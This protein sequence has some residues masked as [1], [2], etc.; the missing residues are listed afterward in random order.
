MRITN[1]FRGIKNRVLWEKNN[2]KKHWFGIS[3]LMLLIGVSYTNNFYLGK[4][5]YENLME[6]INHQKVGYAY[7]MS[8]NKESSHKIVLHEDALVSAGAQESSSDTLSVSSDDDIAGI[9][10]HYFG[11]DSKIALAV[12]KAESNLKPS[13]HTNSNGS[14]D[15]GIFQINSIHQ[16]TKSQCENAEENIKLAHQIFLKKGFGA[17]SAYNNLSYQKYVK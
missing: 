8:F 12:A 15:C 17:W 11:S 16:P 5:Y 3:V 4:P 10:T 1:W 7:A 14:V 13:Y 2:L 9:I 6:F